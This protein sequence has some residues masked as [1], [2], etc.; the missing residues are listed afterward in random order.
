MSDLQG[1]V[2]LPQGHKRCRGCGDVI[3]FMSDEILLVVTDEFFLEIEDDLLP[4]GFYIEKLP[5]G[6]CP[7][8]ENMEN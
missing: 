4:T 8:C 1:I 5:F 7:E 6:I 3:L 2:I